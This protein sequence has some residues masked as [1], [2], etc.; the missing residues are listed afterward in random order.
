LITK[1][2]F[3]PKKREP[4]L[5]FF[6]ILPKIAHPTIIIRF[7]LGIYFILER[8]PNPKHVPINIQAKGECIMG[9]VKGKT[10]VKCHMDGYILGYLWRLL[11]YNES[12]M[13]CCG[14]D[15]RVKG[16]TYPF[17]IQ[18]PKAKPNKDIITFL[19]P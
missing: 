17:K 18:V 11:G 10:G 15:P 14:D 1:N 5:D 8:N 9:E 12:P 7:S 6:N 2:F 3:I 16:Q 19:K 13:R 4:S